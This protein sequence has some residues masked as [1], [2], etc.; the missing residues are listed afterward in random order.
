M[1]AVSRE[2]FVSVLRGLGISQGD[3]LLVH[4]A[5]QFL[6]QP[7]GGI[8]MYCDA[9]CEGLG[10]GKGTIA[11]PAF[12]FSFARGKPFDPKNTPSNGVGVFSEYVRL[13]PGA[14]RTTH[15]MHSLAVIGYRAAD[16]V[17]CDT[18]SAFEPGSAFEKMLGLDFKLLLL[19]ADVQSVSMVHYCEQRARVP[20]RYWK[21]FTG[22]VRVYPTG[23]ESEGEWWTTRTYRMFVRDLDIDPQLNLSP[24]QHLLEERGQWAS[25]PLNYGQVSTCRLVDFVNA[26]DELLRADPWVLVE[27]HPNEKR[28]A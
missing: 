14:Q 5:L 20:Y 11:V 2:Q 8:G 24:I 16:L 3:G 1:Q 26:T 15:P 22:L 17:E 7:E 6:G 18:P 28:N 21:Q 23:G 10:I 4:S 25:R 9:L 19:G 13:L 12:N 27:N